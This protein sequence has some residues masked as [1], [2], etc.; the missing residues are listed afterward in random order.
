MRTAEW[1]AIQDIETVTPE[2]P[3]PVQDCPEEPWLPAWD[4]TLMTIAAYALIALFT[5]TEMFS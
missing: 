2:P 4:V 1:R 5:L 3:P